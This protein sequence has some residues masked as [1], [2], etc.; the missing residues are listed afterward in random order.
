MNAA[1]NI[2]H[3][4]IWQLKL[5]FHHLGGAFSSPLLPASFITSH[6]YR[7]VSRPTLQR[8]HLLHHCCFDGSV[9]LLLFVVIFFFLKKENRWIRLESNCQAVRKAIRYL[10]EFHWMAL[11]KVAKEAASPG[12]SRCSVPRHRTQ[13]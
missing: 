3:A 5:S 6:L 11:K 9:T 13:T 4:G 10:K 2:T 12:S 1:E 8:G 7:S